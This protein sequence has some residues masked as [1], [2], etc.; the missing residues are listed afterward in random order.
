MASSGFWK[1]SV[2]VSPTNSDDIILEKERPT[3]HLNSR[4]PQQIKQSSG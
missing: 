4:K 2:E 1:A 3:K